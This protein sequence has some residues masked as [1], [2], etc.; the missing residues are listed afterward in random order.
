MSSKT[1]QYSAPAPVVI[2]H[3]MWS[4][5]EALADLR[6]HFE[7]GGH[8]VYTP[9]LPYHKPMAEMDRATQA[10]LAK[11]GIGTYVA[12]IR[13]L[14]QGLD[15][16][17]ILIG[18]SMGA[19][20]AQLVAQRTDIEGLVLISSA[21]PAGINAWSWSVIRT[22]GHNLF[23]FPMW[24]VLTDLRP[25]NIRYGIANT[26]SVEVQRDILRLSTYESGLASF[27]LGMWFLF[28]RP[29]T[30]LDTAAIRCP[31]LLVSGR[32]DRITPIQVQR[33]LAQR[34][35]SKATLVELPGVC[36]WTIGGHAFESVVG[37]IDAWM[38]Q[39]NPALE[40]SKAA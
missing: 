27:Q 40:P 36:H 33:K 5:P 28:R 38:S 6:K 8:T 22:F 3:G 12:A 7:A 23:K 17:P 35:G 25:E 18:H 30:R 2:V 31:V 10:G 39:K 20:I 9:A 13:Q 16:P 24:K 15:R 14:V 19:L 1:H 32:E 34:Y 29:A 26:Q 37:E 21:P 11:S 4:T